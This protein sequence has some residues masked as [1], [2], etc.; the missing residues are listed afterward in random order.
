MTLIITSLPVSLP[1]SVGKIHF[2]PAAAAALISLI[3][4][5]GMASKW[6][7]KTT[8]S[9]P[10]NAEARKESEAYEPA[11]IVIEGSSGKVDLESSR[12]TIV[13]LYFRDDARRFFKTR[14]P[15][16]PPA[17]TRA[18]LL[19]VR[20]AIVNCCR[21]HRRWSVY[22]DNVHRYHRCRHPLDNFKG[23]HIF[24]SLATLIQEGAGYF[25]S[26]P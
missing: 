20:D 2:T 5:S 21:F 1:N 16:F 25:L 18:M 24:Y 14:D 15:M 12:L 9:I 26:S 19:I 10:E 4:V 22:V 7:A 17:P 6:R 8:A 3:A 13:M 11:L 23:N